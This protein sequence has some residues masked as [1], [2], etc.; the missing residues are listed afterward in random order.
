MNIL[1]HM[2]PL[3]SS[4][5]HSAGY[6]ADR[7]EAAIRFHNGLLRWYRMDV[8]TF[9]GLITAPSPGRFFNARVKNSKCPGGA[10]TL[11]KYDS[12]VLP[13]GEIHQ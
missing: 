7:G 12:P 5:L 9:Q 11:V 13:K 1:R 8:Q 6:S 2:L 4:Y 3:K 10:E